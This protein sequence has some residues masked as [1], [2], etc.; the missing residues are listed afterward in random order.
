MDVYF[1]V[2]EINKLLPYL[3]KLFTMCFIKDV[4]LNSVTKF[5]CLITMHRLE[6]MLFFFSFLKFPKK[7]LSQ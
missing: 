6:I 3:C 2:I 1:A 7:C 4:Y 5:E